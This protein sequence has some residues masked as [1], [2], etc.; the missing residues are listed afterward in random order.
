MG[1]YVS[2]RSSR[3]RSAARKTAPKE[4]NP[5]WGKVWKVLKEIGV[6]IWRLRGIFISIP[7]LW[8]AI[9]LGVINRARLPEEVGILLMEDGSYKMM[10]SRSTA[11]MAPIMIT[12]GSL[13]LTCLSKRNLFPWLVSVFTLLLP[14]LIWLS[15]IYPA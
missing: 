7:V 15:N 2:R 12:I 5:V 8:V 9:R 1:Q 3:S 13:L 10:V 6:W 14:I 11:V 4:Q